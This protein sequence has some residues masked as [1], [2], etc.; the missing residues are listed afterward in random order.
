MAT[1]L[2]ITSVDYANAPAALQTFSFW[3]KLFSDTSWT[4][5]SNSASV[6]TDGTLGA[7]LNVT[8]LTPDQT[9]YIRGV[10][11][12]E[13]PVAYFIQQVQT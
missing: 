1:E 2:T 11:N 3:Y 4:L 6:N 9:Y 10:A 5:I 12:C 8:G 13:S 7:P